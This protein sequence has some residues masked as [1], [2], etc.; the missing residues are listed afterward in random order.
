MRLATLAE[1]E[2]D[3]SKSLLA[4][5]GESSDSGGSA[6]QSEEDS[7]EE[8][9]LMELDQDEM[10]KLRSEAELEM[11]MRSGCCRTGSRFPVTYSRSPKQ[12]IP[13][14]VGFDDEEDFSSSGEDELVEDKGKGKQKATET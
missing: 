8:E 12:P 13:R 6:P 11:P 9:D 5:A 14:F 4:R 3:K 10:S 1:K 2:K 7:E